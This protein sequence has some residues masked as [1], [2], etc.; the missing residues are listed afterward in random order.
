MEDIRPKFIKHPLLLNDSNDLV[1]G[2][3]VRCSFQPFR[4]TCAYYGAKAVWTEALVAKGFMK[5]SR[6]EIGSQITF[7]VPASTGRP[8]T[9]LQVSKDDKI[10]IVAQF[11][12]FDKQN[13]VSAAL[14]LANDVSAVE[15]NAGCR[16]RFATHAGMGIQLVLKHLDRLCDMVTAL[17]TALP[18]ELPVL[19]KTRILYTPE[20]TT[21][22]LNR[23]KD[24][25]VSMVT[26]HARRPD[27]DR[28]TTKP[29]WNE[30][31]AV[32]PSPVPLIAN[33]G[34]ISHQ[35]IIEIKKTPA[36][37]LPLML[38][39]GAMT[40]PSLL[41]CTDNS[42]ASHSGPLPFGCA[43]RR[44]LSSA[45]LLDTDIASV[46]KFMMQSVG[47]LG[48]TFVRELRSRCHLLTKHVAAS[49]TYDAL[50]H[51]FGMPSEDECIEIGSGVL[52]EMHA[53]EERYWDSVRGTDAWDPIGV[54]SPLV[55]F[56]D[57]EGIEPPRKKV[58][59][60]IK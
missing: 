55:M 53:N 13:V 50:L 44:V 46:K 36:G 60:D 32:L 11:V 19:V 47:P 31:S 34:L 33:G 1:V 54:I 57:T 9:V 15:I 42:V 6:H 49:K 26:L 37:A 12:A 21:D 27:E 24:A 56:R 18:K 16:K 59:P 40:N 8:K 5:A 39:R 29:R 58:K 22:M 10:P 30:I 43:A 23:L 38:A 35:D 20:Q 51:Q 48:R 17:R 7:T 41:L 14:I 25:G 3:M 2:P 52:L 28:R 45:V 4:D